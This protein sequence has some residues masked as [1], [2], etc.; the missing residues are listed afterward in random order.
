MQRSVEFDST[1][2]WSRETGFRIFISAIS[3]TVPT[4]RHLL[5]RPEF[6]LS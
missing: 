4:Q 2:I 5:Y 3:G 6:F 1:N